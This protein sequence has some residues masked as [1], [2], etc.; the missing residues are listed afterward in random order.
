MSIP[1]LGSLNLFKI[2]HG[3]RLAKKESEHHSYDH[4]NQRAS[5]SDNQFLP[6]L[7]GHTL[8][9]GHPTNRE[10]RDIRRGNPKSSRCQDVAEFVQQNAAKERQDKQHARNR[11]RRASYL[12]IGKSDPCQKEEER[13]VD[14]HFRSGDTSDFDGPAHD[15]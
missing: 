3:C 10:Q 13:N 4:V 2:L 1:T 5:D 9:S 11:G 8:K 7:V 14:A 6:R 15:I 12:I